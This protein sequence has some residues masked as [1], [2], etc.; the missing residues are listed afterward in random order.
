MLVSDCRVVWCALV[1]M[2]AVGACRTFKS[3]SCYYLDCFT[4]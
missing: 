2:D 4:R 3:W 1:S